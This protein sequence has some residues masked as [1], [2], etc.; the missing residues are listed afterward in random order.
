[1]LPI[2]LLTLNAGVA[3]THASYQNFVN[4]PNSQPAPIPLG[5]NV[6]NLINASGYEYIQAT[7]VTANLSADC[8]I[9]SKLGDFGYN[10]SYYYN[11]GFFWEANN[12]LRQGS[13]NIVNTSLTWTAPSKK[14][15]VRLWGKNLTD[16][17]YTVFGST[18]P[19][20]DQVA[21]SDPRTFGITLG[22]HF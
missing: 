1:M 4:A 7:K 9:A 17:R 22:A 10:V 13:Y 14:F 3:Y 11:D 5:G 20:G 15:D 18:S 12:R 6:L 21:D 2:E 8:V 19:T 16:K